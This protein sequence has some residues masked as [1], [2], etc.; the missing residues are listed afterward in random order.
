MYIYIYICV[1]AYSSP[2]AFSNGKAPPV[3]KDQFDSA[4]FLNKYAVLW[5]EARTLRLCVDLAYVSASTFYT[6]IIE[7]LGNCL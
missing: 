5:R 3:C 6:T 4:N 1:F 7:V 2:K